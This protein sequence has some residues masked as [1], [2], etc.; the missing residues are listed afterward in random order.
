M[1]STPQPTINLFVVMVGQNLDFLGLAGT[2]HDPADAPGT[3][4]MAAYQG[5]F[6]PTGSGADIAK[7]EAA[8]QRGILIWGRVWELRTAA[9]HSFCQC[10][11]ADVRHRPYSLIGAGYAAV[12]S[13]STA[14][15]STEGARNALGPRRTH[16]PRRLAASRHAEVRI[17]ASPPDPRRPAHGV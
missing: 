15:E 16:G 4:R 7:N 5:R 17:T 8:M 10:R 3:T 9:D 14:L 12:P 6:T 1:A 2:G 13:S 11:D